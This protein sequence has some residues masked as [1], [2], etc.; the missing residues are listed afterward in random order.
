MAEKT[1]KYKPVKITPELLR[2]P[3]CVECFTDIRTN[4]HGVL[5]SLETHTEELF[6]T[7]NQKFNQKTDIAIKQMEVKTDDSVKKYLEKQEQKHDNQ[8]NEHI[9][10]QVISHDEKYDKYLEKQDKRENKRSLYNV[11]IVGIL[12]SIL[13]YSLLE[14]KTIGETLIL[15]KQDIDAKPSK[16]EVPTMTEMQMLRELGDEYNRNVFV[17]KIRVTADTSAYFWSK[18]NI[19][20]SLMRGGGDKFYKEE[21]DKVMKEKVK[22]N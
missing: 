13:G 3:E 14:Q 5:G 6:D 22:V 21:Y 4:C 19:Y 10:K 8:F 17:R 15:L 16:K 7:L 12:V 9:R 20:G 1:P 18:I 11:L 2:T